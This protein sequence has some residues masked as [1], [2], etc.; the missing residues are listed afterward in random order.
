MKLNKKFLTMV[1]LCGLAGLAVSC[2]SDTYLYVGTSPDY[3]PYEFIDSSKTGD[4]QY[5]GSDIELAKHI[6]LKQNKVLKLEIMQFEEILSSV[7]TGKVDLAISG[8]TYKKERADNY[9]MSISYYDDGEGDQVIITTK[10]KL[11]TLSSKEQLNNSN[12]T[13]AAQQGSV[14][15]DYVNEQLPDA[16]IEVIK[17]IADAFTYLDGGKVDAVAIASVVA[18]VK[19]SQSENYS[20]TDF[21]FDVTG[22]TG[23]FAI[24]KKGNKELIESV[25]SIIADVKSNGLYNT[26]IS[27]AK[28]LADKINKNN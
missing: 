28:A 2:N 9:E 24:A 23:L 4:D 7:Q 14:Q 13:I 11:Q 26:W 19:L 22:K 3:A 17:N 15:Y 8:F 1:G 20:L 18:N 5:V 25:N 27:N 12:V 16:K 10:E 6:A 21:K